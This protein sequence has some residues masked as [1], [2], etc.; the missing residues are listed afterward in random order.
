MDGDAEFNA[1][2]SV[3]QSI[4]QDMKVIFF[5]QIRQIQVLIKYFTISIFSIFLEENIFFITNVLITGD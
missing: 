3:Y 5:L 2:A 1:L 4:M